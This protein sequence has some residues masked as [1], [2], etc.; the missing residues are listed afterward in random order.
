[1][2]ACNFVICRVFMRRLIATNEATVMVFMSTETESGGDMG[3]D[4]TARRERCS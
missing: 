3:Q 1:M 2:V 4:H